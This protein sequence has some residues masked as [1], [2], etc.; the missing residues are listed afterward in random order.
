MQN[1]FYQCNNLDGVFEITKEIL[2]TPVL[3]IDDIFDS[4]ATI[5][6]IG[7]LFTQLG[8]LKIAPLV[9]AKTVGSDVT[10]ADYLIKD[11]QN[12]IS[13]QE[14][15]KKGI[16]EVNSS[17]KKGQQPAENIFLPQIESDN[18]IITQMKLL[19]E[20]VN[21]LTDLLGKTNTTKEKI[22]KEKKELNS[23]AS[24]ELLKRLKKWRYEKS[25]ELNLPCFCIMHDK[26]ILI[27]AE[28]MPKSVKDLTKIKGFGQVRIQQYGDDILNIIESCQNLESIDT[29]EDT[30]SL[31]VPE[32]TE[33]EEDEKKEEAKTTYHERLDKIHEKYFTIS[34]SFPHKHIA[35]L[36]S[37]RRE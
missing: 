17:N 22:I 1:R 33:S 12:F 20:K 8:A 7:T 2:S 26:T 18:Q 4:G 25:Q 29:T 14:I 21:Y 32:R 28:Q 31:V 16:T 9:I 13:K 27:I 6:E 30:A 10:N 11:R 23:E 34:Q 36:V 35:I 3:L 15:L 37:N 5:K 19:Q 24:K